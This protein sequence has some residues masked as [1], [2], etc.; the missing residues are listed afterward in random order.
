MQTKA[1]TIVLIISNMFSVNAFGQNDTLIDSPINFG[2][3]QSTISTKDAIIISKQQEQAYTVVEEMPEF[4]GGESALMKYLIKNIKY[5]PEAREQNIQGKVV[6]KFIVTRV[7]KIDSV[8]VLKPIHASLD[9][10][11]IRVIKSMPD[12]K[13][14]KQ[15]GKAVNVYYSLPINFKLEERKKN[16]ESEH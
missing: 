1:A 13:P 8:Y 15:N 4:P 14:G 11:A 7:G 10:E 12:W 6:V 3:P 5:P 16:S 9:E 2:N